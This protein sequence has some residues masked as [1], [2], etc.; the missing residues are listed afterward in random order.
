MEYTR[1]KWLDEFEML[2]FRFEG[3]EAVLVLP[4]ERVRTPRWLLKTEYFGAFPQLESELIRRG[5]HLAY[6]KNNNRWGTDDDLDT[7]K[8]F[9][10]FLM[11]EFGLSA[12]CVPIG[13]S[14][15]G[16]HA[17]K[18]A[19]RHPGMIAALYLDAPVV[20]LL[21]CPM[22]IGEGE[23]RAAIDEMLEALGLN[24]AEFMAYRRHPLDCLP[25]IVKNEIPV[26]LVCGDSDGTVPY[27]E[28]GY[29]VKQACEKAGTPFI[30]E[31]KKGC[32]HHPHGPRNMG[33]IIEFIERYTR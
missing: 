13:M 25:E 26:A 33:R 7:K 31:L 16:L 30:F 24:L 12:R 18:Q 6:L 22:S 15:G 14:C 8:R 5:F 1:G 10:D 19:A 4:D 32:D 17:I 2:S 28:N 11:E 23:Y 3:R 9:R 20:N 27:K 21:S 29:F